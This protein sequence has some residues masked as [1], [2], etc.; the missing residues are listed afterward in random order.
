MWLTYFEQFLSNTYP[1]LLADRPWNY[2]NDLCVIGA[3][4]LA[5]VTGD[6]KWLAY[7]VNNAH[8]LL[9]EDGTIINCPLDEHNMDKVSFKLIKGEKYNIK[10]FNF[11]TMH[12]LKCI[13]ER[14]AINIY[15]I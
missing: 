10:H 1:K 4:Q 14:L 9:D 7:I 15:F 8:Y 2:K 12:I 13:I 5:R 3:Y 6:D 11:Y